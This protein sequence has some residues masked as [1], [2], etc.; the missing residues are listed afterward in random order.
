M[1]PHTARTF[2]DEETDKRPTSL[3]AST[4]HPVVTLA[5]VVSREVRFRRD[6]Y[7]LSTM[8]DHLLSDIGIGRSQ[9]ENAVRN[10][11]ISSWTDKL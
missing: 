4:L 5:A 8:D 6:Q 3:I 10:G 1:T 7:A 9:I 11:R 2:L